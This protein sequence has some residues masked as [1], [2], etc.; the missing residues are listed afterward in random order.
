MTGYKFV[1]AGNKLTWDGAIGMNS[2]MGKV[3]AVDSAFPCDFK[4]DAGKKPKQIDIT[5]HS[6]KGR[7]DPPGHLRNQGRHVESVFFSNNTGQAPGRVFP[8]GQG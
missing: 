3:T 8:K 1:F 6:R 7:P 5:L 4:I 2:R